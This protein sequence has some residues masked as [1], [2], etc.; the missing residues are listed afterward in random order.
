M[1]T[2]DK[3]GFVFLQGVGQYSR[4]IKQVEEDIQNCLKKVNELTGK[5][6]IL[7]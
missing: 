5:H 2:E 4:S 7:S 3:T 6:E 1:K